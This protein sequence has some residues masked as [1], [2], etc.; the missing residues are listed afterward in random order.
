MI[1]FVLA[2]LKY[3]FHAG[4]NG[5]S[6]EVPPKNEQDQNKSAIKGLSSVYAKQQGRYSFHLPK[7]S[8][9]S[10]IHNCGS[11]TS[12]RFDIASG[13]IFISPWMNIADHSKPLGHSDCNDPYLLVRSFYSEIAKSSTWW[14]GDRGSKP[15]ASRTLLSHFP[16]LYLP[17]PALFS[18]APDPYTLGDS[19]HILVS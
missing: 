10:L 13:R 18:P 7:F 6:W 1:T 8:L 16:H 19:K 15:T 4:T 3:P 11:W 2:L 14:G 9:W 12:S 17:A 5:M